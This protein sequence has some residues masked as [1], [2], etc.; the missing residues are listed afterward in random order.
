MRINYTRKIIITLLLWKS[1]FPT[2]LNLTGIARNDAQNYLQPALEIITAQQT[3][4]MPVASFTNSPL[5]GV[6][7]S[8]LSGAAP[9]FASAEFGY[10]N[11]WFALSVSSN[12]IIGAHFTGV[13]WLDD[14]IHTVGPFVTTG[15][16]TPEKSINAGFHFHNLKGPDDF[17]LTDVALDVTRVFRN[18]K[19]SWGYGVTAHFLKTAFHV[20]DNQDMDQ[21][22]KMTTDINIIFTRLCVYRILWKN[23]SVGSEI[24][25]KPDNIVTTMNISINL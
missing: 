16:G 4:L 19:W 13:H 10:P 23:V 6:G 24:F 18:T 12:L 1:I 8:L 2:S 22:Y 3:P 5:L 9:G 7:A 25:L 17:H 15:W 14:N 20:T 21:N 11:F